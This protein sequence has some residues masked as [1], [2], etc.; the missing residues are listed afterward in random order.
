M[1]YF[2]KNFERQKLRFQKAKNNCNADADA[3]VNADADAEMI[4]RA[5][6]HSRVTDIEGILWITN[7]KKIFHIWFCIGTRKVENEYVTC[8][9]HKTWNKMC[10]STVAQTK[11]TLM[12]FKTHPVIC[13]GD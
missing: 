12:S 13:T 1:F 5:L 11:S 10:S 9:N 8:R 7:C 4:V 3:D 2:T 6:L